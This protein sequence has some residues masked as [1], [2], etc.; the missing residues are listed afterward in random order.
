MKCQVLEENNIT[1][2]T[3]AESY[4]W[5]ALVRGQDV[6][7]IKPTGPDSSVDG[8]E[9]LRCRCTG[10]LLPLLTHLMAPGLYQKMPNGTGVSGILITFNSFIRRSHDPVTY[11]ICEGQGMGMKSEFGQISYRNYSRMIVQL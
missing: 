5:P 1:V 10:Y 3:L 2:P 11:C 9:T 7:V 6:V 8:E 4:V